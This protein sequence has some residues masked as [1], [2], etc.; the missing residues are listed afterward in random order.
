MMRLDRGQH[1]RWT[2]AG[3]NPFVLGQHSEPPGGIDRADPRIHDRVVD[4]PNLDIGH[5]VLPYVPIAALGVFT[6]SSARERSSV[7][8]DTG[9]RLIELGRCLAGRLA[10]QQLVLQRDYNAVAVHLVGEVPVAQNPRGDWAQRS[11]V[12]RKDLI[13]A[14]G[15]SSFRLMAPVMDGWHEV[16]YFL[17]HDLRHVDPMG[18]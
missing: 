14:H 2:L 9:Q 10:Y 1:L 6:G 15:R 5:G 7:G 3:V 16:G 11:A 17:P 12:Q 18:I 4:A 8:G 13:R